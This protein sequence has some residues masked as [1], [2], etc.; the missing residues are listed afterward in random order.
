MSGFG[1]TSA[2]AVDPTHPLVN[3]HTHHIRLTNAKITWDMT[4]CPAYMPPPRQRAF[5]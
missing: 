1:T 4:G 3:P 5:R 2:G